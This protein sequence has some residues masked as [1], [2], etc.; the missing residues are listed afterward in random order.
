MYSME[1]KY[2]ALSFTPDATIEK[3]RIF[4]HKKEFKEGIGK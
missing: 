3:T 4:F 2:K 1:L